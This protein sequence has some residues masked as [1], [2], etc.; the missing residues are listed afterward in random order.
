M[1]EIEELLREALHELADAIPET[2]PGRLSAVAP[3]RRR[4]LRSRAGWLG[5]VG[6]ALAVAVL[7]ALSSTVI[8]LMP[9]G[10]ADGE[11]ADSAG[12]PPVYVTVES[13]APSELTVRETGSGIV[14]ATYRSN[15][16]QETFGLVGAAG[17]DRTFFVAAADS[18]AYCGHVVLYRMRVSGTGKIVGF[19]RWATQPAGEYMISGRP[20]GALAVSSDGSQVAY[21][22]MLCDAASGD[23][24][25][26]SAVEVMR[27]GRYPSY[28]V[29]HSGQGLPI[30]SL[31]WITG[32]RLAV[33]GYILGPG[34][35]KV[36]LGV[37][38]VSA[39]RPGATEPTAAPQVLGSPSDDRQLLDAVATTD[40]RKLIAAVAPRGGRPPSFGIDSA[41]GFA[42]GSASGSVAGSGMDSATGLATGGGKPTV[43]P[44]G[45]SQ[46]ERVTILEYA[47]DGG[48]SG[49]QIFTASLP[50]SPARVMLRR[51]GGSDRLL[52]LTG[53]R[54]YR[55]DGEGPRLADAGPGLLDV[56]W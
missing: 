14:R 51:A 30:R 10:D 11:A 34:D 45:A 52:I 13:G 29:W 12:G 25:R 47:L 15:S 24:M 38:L 42:N 2:V 22:G 33:V 5:P 26:S 43:V 37:R 7:V 49:R 39:P 44:P 8:A 50:V 4:V 17:D 46:T 56:A 19:T 32:G 35:P 54:V 55:L 16:P 41:K 18:G 20:D 40:G 48:S 9:K 28:W 53:A 21:G 36:S 27:G 1:S 6:A 3:R 31:S 23:G